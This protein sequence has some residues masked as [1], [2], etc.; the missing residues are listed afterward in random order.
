MVASH[1]PVFR[2]I[3]GD[4]AACLEP[5]EA[6]RLVGLARLGQKVRPRRVATRRERPGRAVILSPPPARRLRATE[7]RPAAARRRGADGFVF[8]RRVLRQWFATTRSAVACRTRRWRQVH[9]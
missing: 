7:I 8:T 4:A 2:R 9:V 1:H 6:R 3:C 5:H